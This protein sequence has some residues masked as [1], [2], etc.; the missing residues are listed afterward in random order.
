[1]KILL[2]VFI[3]LFLLIVFLVYKITNPVFGK[4]SSKERLRD[5]PVNTK[6]L[7]QDVKSLT[8]IRPFRNSQNP[9]GMQKAVDY[10]KFELE[11]AGYTTQLQSFQTPDGQTYQNVIAFYGQPKAE[12]VVIGAHYDV[13]DNQP[14]ADDNASAVAGLLE[15]ARLLQTQK[16]DLP[17]QI[18]LVAYANEEPPYFRT[19]YMGSAVH[20]QSLK[21][22]QIKLKAMICLEMI[23]Y[24]SDQPNSQNY[25]LAALKTIYPSVGNFIAVVGKL[26]QDSLVAQVKKKMLTN[27]KIDVYSIN[28]PEM[29]TGIDFSDHLN[30]WAMGYP[31][32]MIT[33]TSFFRNQNY[34]QSTDTI[35]TL[36]FDKMTEV[37]KGVYAAVI[38]L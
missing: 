20:A 16:P 30:Y 38:G 35:D 17:Y 8:D 34:H 19:E 28:S 37:V 29:V 10:V 23:G 6:N 11:K 25:P 1:M 24:F 13:C 22:Q 3:I 5:I 15:I 32:V 36:D 21:N 18:E 27:S 26:G 12:R 7:Y 4:S 9:T 33:D 31:A 14:G 2:I